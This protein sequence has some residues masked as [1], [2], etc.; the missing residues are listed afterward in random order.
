[1]QRMDKTN[2]YLDIAE[3]VS[4]RSTCLRRCY[5]AIIVRSDEIISTGYNGAPRGRKNCV[6]LGRCLR[7][8]LKIP[9]GERYELCRS[10]HAEANAIIS[11]AR[12]D[13]IGGTLYL[14][15]RNA[16]TGELL[17]DA[18][19]CSMCRRLIINA[20]IVKVICRVGENEYVSCDVDEWIKQDDSLYMED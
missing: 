5:G 11:A 6:D 13:A 4:R 16:K 1:M 9:S 17:S 2:Y 12:R 20:G 18:S 15:G 14:A 7:D 10:V 19:P 3:A 8:E